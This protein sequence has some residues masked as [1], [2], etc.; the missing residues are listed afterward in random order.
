MSAQMVH[1][2]LANRNR[3]NRRGAILVLSAI[4][5]FMMLAFLA[6]TV[7]TGYLASSKAEIRRSADAAAIAGCWELYDELVQG[8]SLNDAESGVAAEAATYA[9]YN[10]VANAGP[11]LDVSGCQRDVEVGY[12]SSLTSNAISE[13]ANLPYFAVNVRVNR[14]AQQNGEIPYFFG[15]IFG[16]SGRPLDATATAVMARNIS[17]FSTPGSCHE[18]VDILPFALDLQTWNSIAANTASDT[19]YYNPTTGQVTTGADG[20]REVNLYPQGTGSPGNRGTVDIGGAN[21]STADIARQIL[22]GISQDDIQAL[23]KPL[24]LTNG[25]MTLNG[26]TGIS[27][28]VKD[29]LASIIGQPRIIPIFSSVSGNGNNAQYT[30]VKWVGVRILKVKLTGAMSSKQVIIQ[31]APIIARNAVFSEANTLLSEYVY[32]PV[33]LAH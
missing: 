18:T 13:D 3:R 14:T 2:K 16:D 5:M 26:D 32:S 6:F 4:M 19:H 15:R 11:G 33:L 8:R 28:G 23:G 1:R 21:N 24:N 7:D 27:A 31:P 25:Q 20:I 17:G 12:L 29:E 9:G 10:Q 30:I 22:H